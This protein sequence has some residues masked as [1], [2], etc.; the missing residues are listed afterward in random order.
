MRYNDDGEYVCLK[1]KAMQQ[2]PQAA[3]SITTDLQVM[4]NIQFNTQSDIQFDRKNDHFVMCEST[5]YW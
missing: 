4:H 5:I 2:P 1:L 3:H